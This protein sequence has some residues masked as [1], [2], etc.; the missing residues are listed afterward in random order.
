MQR[1]S[2]QKPYEVYLVTLSF[3]T[4]HDNHVCVFRK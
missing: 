3:F 4:D 1:T 2:T